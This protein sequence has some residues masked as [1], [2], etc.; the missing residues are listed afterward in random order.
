M[1]NCS[2]ILDR[3]YLE[4]GFALRGYA[5]CQSDDLKLG[6]GIE[7]GKYFKGGRSYGKWGCKVV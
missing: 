6:A 4:V 1:L 7:K 2:R 3:L 5:I